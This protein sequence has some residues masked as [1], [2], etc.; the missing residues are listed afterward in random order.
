MV[1]IQKFINL[2]DINMNKY[3]TEKVFTDIESAFT[4]K[5]CLDNIGMIDRWWSPDDIYSYLHT[6]RFLERRIIDILNGN[7]K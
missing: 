6:K 5:D 2:I 4:Y 3:E 1:E 7:L